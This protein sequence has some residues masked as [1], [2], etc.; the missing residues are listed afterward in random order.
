MSEKNVSEKVFR[1]ELTMEVAPGNEQQFEEAWLEVGKAVSEHPD[2]IAQWLATSREAPGKYVIVSDWPDEASFRRFE[3][4]HEQA[5]LTQKL[6]MMRTRGSME[7]Q[8]VLHHLSGARG[9]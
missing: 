6:R 4:A 9:P 1:V 8:T 3:Q 2:N 5:E 7:T